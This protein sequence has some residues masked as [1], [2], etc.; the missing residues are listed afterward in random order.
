MGDR[1]VPVFERFFVAGD[2]FDLAA[3]G[4]E[5]VEPCFFG[6]M[7]MSASSMAAN[8]D[9][10]AASGV[11]YKVYQTVNNVNAAHAVDKIQ[12]AAMAMTVINS[13]HSWLALVIHL[14]FRYGLGKHAHTQQ[15]PADNN[16][17]T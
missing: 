12:T 13:V 7:M 16:C 14:E 6:A 2:G 5:P 15:Q 3:F 10:N 1:D 17:T 11:Y 8:A 9:H 4:V